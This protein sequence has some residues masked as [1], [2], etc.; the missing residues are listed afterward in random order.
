[1]RF[2]WILVLAGCGPNAATNLLCTY[3]ED[4]SQCHGNPCFQDVSG[5]RF[6]GKPCE[7]GCP[8]GFSCQPVTGTG[9]SGMSCFPDT[10]ICMPG[11]DEP[12]MAIAGP[13]QDLAG[14]DLSSPPLP[15]GGSVSASG[16]SVDRLLF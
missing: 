12:D 14:R 5:S 10:E 1:M 7:T 11:A 13:P 2:A 9:G 6:C 15:V 4:D 8:E 16:G 3:C